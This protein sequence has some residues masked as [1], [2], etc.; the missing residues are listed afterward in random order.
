MDGFLGVNGNHV[1]LFL[2]PLD[3]RY[4]SFAC[5]YCHDFSSVLIL[6]KPNMRN[7]F[8]HLLIMLSTMDSVFI[9]L[10]IVDYSFVR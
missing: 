1:A 4:S 6:S 7:S 9:V 5:F 2:A 10:A 8:N 3:I